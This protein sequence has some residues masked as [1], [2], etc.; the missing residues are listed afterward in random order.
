MQNNNI[1]PKCEFWNIKQASSWLGLSVD[2]VYKMTRAGKLPHIKIGGRLCFE[3][4]R[5]RTYI[6]ECR[7][8]P[9]NF[10]NNSIRKEWQNKF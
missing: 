2:H 10:T 3:E 6:N 1:I 7:V 4:S 9:T 5:L 8:E